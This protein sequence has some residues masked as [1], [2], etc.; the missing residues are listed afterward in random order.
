MDKFKPIS[1]QKIV[2]NTMIIGIK[3]I[4]RF[5]STKNQSIYRFE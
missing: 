2:S 4:N 5:D 3:S 1:M